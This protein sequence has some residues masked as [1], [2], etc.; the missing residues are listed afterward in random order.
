[1]AFQDESDHGLPCRR[2]ICPYHG[3][4]YNLE[5]ELLAAAGEQDLPQPFQRS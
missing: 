5:G 4:T 2:L 1:M 3:W